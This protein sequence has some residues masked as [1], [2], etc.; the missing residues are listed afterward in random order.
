MQPSSLRRM[1]DQEQ[2]FVMRYFEDFYN[3]VITL[4]RQLQRSRT[5]SLSQSNGDTINSSAPQILSQL[6]YTLEQQTLSVGRQGGEFATSYYL[7][8]Q[9]I[10]AVLA[11]EIF[12]NFDWSGRAYWEDHLLESQLFGTHDAGDLFFQ[13]LDE[14][15]RQRDVARQD[16]AE[17]Y[18][19][20]LGLGF[21][22]RYRGQNAQSRLAT[23]KHEL[24]T[25]IHHR[26]LRFYNDHERLFPEAYAHTLTERTAKPLRDT[27]LW[28]TAFAAVAFIILG[29]SHIFWRQAVGD[30]DAQIDN[31]DKRKLP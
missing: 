7:E 20:A 21:Q 17:I 14:F 4:K 13:R 28:Y 22:G 23:Y 5:P 19:L 31:I 15:L 2:S 18:L 6:K 8:A 26:E 16:L 29:C 3:Q 24:Y 10:M 11:D 9:Y 12:L 27:R 25:F 30:L 1:D